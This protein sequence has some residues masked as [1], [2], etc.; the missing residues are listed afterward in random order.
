MCG[1]N[2]TTSQ[3]G[4]TLVEATISV[5]VVGVLTC[6][7]LAALGT[8]STT[9]LKQTHYAKAYACATVFMSEILQKPY[10]DGNAFGPQSGATRATYV[11]VDDYNGYT[12]SPPAFINGTAMAGYSSYT[13]SVTVAYLNPATLAVTGSDMGLKR[14]TVTVTDAAGRKTVLV[15]LRS[16]YGRCDQI[17]TT[18]GTYV[19]HL[20]LDLQ[21]GTDSRVRI[22]QGVNPVNVIP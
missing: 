14:I 20:G 22:S 3:R 16:Q 6:A 15:G 19:S 9:K 12:Q 10:S 8:A 7:A 17:P 5:F 13:V 4:F 18:S 2:R 1:R 11:D 21:V